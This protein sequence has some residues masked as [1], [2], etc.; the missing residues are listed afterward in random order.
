MQLNPHAMVNAFPEGLARQVDVRVERCH[1]DPHMGIVPKI[2]SHAWSDIIH[3]YLIFCAPRKLAQWTIKM[4]WVDLEREG[5]DWAE[6]DKWWGADL[7]VS[8]ASKWNLISDK[9]ITKLAALRCVWTHQL[10]NP[11]LLPRLL[12]YRCVISPML[13]I[14]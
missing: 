11:T 10:K 2:A 8:Y 9:E 3:F 13:S 7:K 4:G 5:T 1:P 6:W 14:L 12:A